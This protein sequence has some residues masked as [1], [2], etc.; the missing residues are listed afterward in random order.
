MK[1]ESRP[2]HEATTE[3]RPSVRQRMNDTVSGF[4]GG[5]AVKN[6]PARQETRVRSLLRDDP[7]S[8]GTTKPMSHNDRACALEPESRD[9]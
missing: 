8:H 4:H 3:E 6:P 5:P 2:E 7:T 9:C 1:G